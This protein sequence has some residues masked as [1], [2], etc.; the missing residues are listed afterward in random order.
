MYVSVDG[1]KDIQQLH[2]Y[3][4]SSKTEETNVGS[5]ATSN[6]IFVL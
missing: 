3:N 5:I 1:K 6:Y 2:L 4:N